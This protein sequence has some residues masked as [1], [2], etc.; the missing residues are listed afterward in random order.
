MK[1]NMY[2]KNF[3]PLPPLASDVTDQPPG[4]RT[5]QRIS[6]TGTTEVRNQV[7]LASS[8]LHLLMV[9]GVAVRV[10]FSGAVIAANAVDPTRDMVLG[11]YTQYPFTEEEGLSNYVY[12]EAA[13]GVTAYVATVHK[14][15]P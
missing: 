1:G 12:L 7:K 15:Q 9:E 11:P 14:V 6:G 2:Y 3:F 4:G 8:K 10:R 5:C 13:D